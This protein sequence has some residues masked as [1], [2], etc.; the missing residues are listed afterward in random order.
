MEIK[1][2]EVYVNERLTI[3]WIV[4]EDEECKDIQ[5]VDGGYIVNMQDG[6]KKKYKGFPTIAVWE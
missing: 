5:E 4:E 3:H 6:S 1:E 2:L